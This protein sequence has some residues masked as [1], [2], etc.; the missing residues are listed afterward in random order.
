MVMRLLHILFISGAV[1]VQSA[2]AQAPPKAPP[3]AP[4][5]TKNLL[6]ENPFVPSLPVR[7]AS[8][9]RDALQRLLQQYPPSL[10]QVLRLDPSLLTN[11]QYLAPYPNLSAFLMQHPEVAHNP[12]YF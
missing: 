10:G 12:I 5:A 1:A 9:V 6:V 3:V 2:A 7:D 11:P 4:P 8:Q